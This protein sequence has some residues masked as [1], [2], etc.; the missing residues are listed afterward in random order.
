MDLGLPDS[1]D[2]YWNYTRI[3][4]I[5]KVDVFLR[6][7][8]Y[9]SITLKLPKKPYKKKA[10]TSRQ[11]VTFLDFSEFRFVHFLESEPF[12]VQNG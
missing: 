6:I 7:S 1:S 4:Q 3:R 10:Y 2:A 9:D 8:H 11:N 12:E 5:W